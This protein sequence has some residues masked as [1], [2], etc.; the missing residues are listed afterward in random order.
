MSEYVRLL[1]E[2]IGPRLLLMPAVVVLPRDDADRLLLV[3][4]AD[5]KLWGC[6]GGAV[7]PG[8][9]PAAAAVRECRE[10]T[11]LDVELGPLVGAVGGTG[12]EV[13]YGTGDRVAYV[14]TVYDARVVSGELR[15]DDDEV[16]RAAWFSLPAIAGLELGSFCTQLFA[17]LGVAG[18]GAARPR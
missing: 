5:T 4:H 15:P 8:E 17:D 2:V 12:Y 7:D 3:R 10:E 1:R 6:V 18:A 16:D 9:S 14:A 13:I 11:G